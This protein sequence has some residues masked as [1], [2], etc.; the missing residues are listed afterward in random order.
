MR[1]NKKT[2]LLSAV[3]LGLMA[4]NIDPHIVNAATDTGTNNGDASKSVQASAMISKSN[5]NTY[6]IV[7][8]GETVY[9]I[10]NKYNISQ[11]EL[12]VWNNLSNNI[13]HTDQILSVNGINVYSNIIKET[14]RFN[15]TNQFI[16]HVAPIAL[17]VAGK[18]QLYPS[19]MIAQATLETGSGT[20]KRDIPLL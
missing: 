7:R 18:Y 11:E 4:S 15:S 9:S 10:S 17:E 3:T 6:H 8:K 20:S 14:H 16:Q 13:I 12:T 2:L 1:Y 19:V 5:G